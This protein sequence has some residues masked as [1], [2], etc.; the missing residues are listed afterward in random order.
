[1][2]D[3]KRL[4]VHVRWADA[5]ADGDPGWRHL[6]EI[7]DEGEYL[8]DTVGWLLHVGDGGQTGHVTVAQSIGERDDAVDHVINIPLGMVRTI[9]VCRGKQVDLAKVMPPAP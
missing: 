1:M 6:E 7:E 4:L 9:S 8:V 3:G 2:S 5:W